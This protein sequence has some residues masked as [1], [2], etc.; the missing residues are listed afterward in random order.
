MIIFDLDGTLLNT[1]KDLHTALNH[2]LKMHGF[3]LKTE[4]ETVA[5]LGNGID[6]LVAGAIEDGK[7]NPKF[8]E[9]YATFK[10]YYTAHLNDYTQ[11]YDGVIELLTELKSRNIKMGIVSNKFDE[12]FR[13]SIPVLVKKLTKLCFVILE[14]KVKLSFAI[15]LFPASVV[16]IHSSTMSEIVKF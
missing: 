6:I 2:A 7:S 15:P 10:K 13:F 4:A 11:P 9:T 5:L 14:I 1:V 8:E 16:L 12:G 3:P